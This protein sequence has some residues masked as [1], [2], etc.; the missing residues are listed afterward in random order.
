MG[1]V[2][3]VGGWVWRITKFLLIFI[4][5]WLCLFFLFGSLQD[6]PKGTLQEK[7][8][9]VVG[10]DTI[11]TP[12]TPAPAPAEPKKKKKLPVTTNSIAT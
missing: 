1:S 5:P 3:F 7:L 9:H 6:V 10:K 8:R 12:P 4:V 2:G 11:S